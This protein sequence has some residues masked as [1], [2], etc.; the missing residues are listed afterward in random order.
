MTHNELKQACSRVLERMQQMPDLEVALQLEA[1]GTQ[2]R[3]RSEFEGLGPL[4][5]WME[6]PQCTEIIV[7]G[8]NDIWVENGGR[9]HSIGDGFLSDVTFENFRQRLAR[10][11][12]LAPNF[13][14]PFADG[15]WRG[16]R[17]H[18]AQ[19]PVASETQITIRTRPPAPWTLA[20]LRDSGWAPESAI[21]ILRGWLAERRNLLVVGP[22]GAGK[23]SV[24]NALLQELDPSER[25]ICI[26]DTSEL[27]PMPGASCKLLTRSDANGVLKD[28]HLTDLLRQSL[29]MRPSRLVLGEVRGPEAKDLLMALA[30]GHHGSL[31]T[32]HAS[33]A[34]QALLRLEMLVQLGAGQWDR[35][36]IRQLIQ[37][38]VDGIIVTGIDE[39]GRRLEGLYRIASLE[40]FGFLIEAVWRK[41]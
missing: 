18:V 41:S 7:P 13:N 36:A 15:E 29:R 14:I 30:T 27:A 35:D 38:S 2:E 8:C 11:A 12:D 3:L 5:L 33:D 9:F 25:A 21:A 19:A 40:S 4:Q 31:G 26:E 23:T 17:V 22:T 20:R 16:C 37:L 32:L 10:E 1:P 34:K 24:L 28:Y 6:N 39:D